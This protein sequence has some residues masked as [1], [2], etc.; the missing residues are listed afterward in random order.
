M[1]HVLRIY[2]FN[3]QCFLGIIVSTLVVISR[4]SNRV[5]PDIL[6]LHSPV[7][8]LAPMSLGCMFLDVGR[9]RWLYRR[10]RTDVKCRGNIGKGEGVETDE[11]QVN[12]FNTRSRDLGWLE[13]DNSCQ[14]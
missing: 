11:G 12:V 14:V 9:Y 2:P 10:L 8:A 3:T 7:N 6:A 13:C 5:F 4:S 1:F